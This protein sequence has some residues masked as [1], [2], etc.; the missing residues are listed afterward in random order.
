MMKK[1]VISLLVGCFA[2]IGGYAALAQN[3]TN[4]NSSIPANINRAVPQKPVYDGSCMQAAVDKRDSAIIVAWDAYSV[5]MKTALST[6]KDALKAA[7]AKSAIAE[8]R[9]ALKAAW[10]AYRKATQTSR[11]ALN[12]AKR[13]AWNQ[14][15][16]DRKACK[17]N[18]WDDAASS[19]SDAG[20]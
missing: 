13:E 15:S 11:N 2:L 10:E 16:K 9:T 20:L 3:A 8:R 14:F 12:K 19:A 6:R 5:S 4:T 7:W 18:V 1:I 17:S